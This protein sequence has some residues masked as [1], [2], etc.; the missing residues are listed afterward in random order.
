ME[1]ELVDPSLRRLVSRVGS[2]DLSKASARRLARLVGG[3]QVARPERGVQITQVRAGAA[4]LR[5]YRPAAPRQARPAA[6]LLWIHGG[7]Y[8]FGR[9]RQDD[10]LCARVAR[11]LGLP[12][13]S[14]E[15][16]MA[17]EH[18]FPAALED[19]AAAWAWLAGQAD[20][21]ESRGA[22][23]VR[24]GIGG[25]SAGGGLAAGL[26]QRLRDAAGR[27]PAAQWLFAPM[28]DDRTG[29]N[30]DLDQ[31]EHWV[32]ANSAN[33]AAWRF[34]LGA[35]PG[36]AALPPYASPGRRA[37]LSGLPPTYI[38]MGDI[39]LFH[40]EDLAYAER[41]AAAGVPV[42]TDVVPG[43]PHAIIHAD[44]IPVARAVVTRALAWL[45]ATLAPPPAPAP[46]PN[47][48]DPGM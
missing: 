40:A 35:E 27:Q 38:T 17:P 9:A 10:F 42:A 11:E 36:A 34:Y 39:E 45:A 13:A 24:L 41:L 44:R 31:I 8:L 37:D 7:G 18:P 16:R 22:G 26:V 4:R 5:L 12:V 1:I 32:W 19:V 47:G 25:E 33:R 21:A 6:G 23:P 46:P 15:Y 14:A 29:A 2:V 43:A 28:L 48:A 30:R 3:L 20:R